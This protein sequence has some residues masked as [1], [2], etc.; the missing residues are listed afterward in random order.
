M[1]L[2]KTENYCNFMQSIVMHI[3]QNA[4]YKVNHLW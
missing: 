4:V 1:H 3:M 2:E